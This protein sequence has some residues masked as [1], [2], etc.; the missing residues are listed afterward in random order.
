MLFRSAF[1]GH[2]WDT[3]VFGWR[4][5]GIGYDPSFTQANGGLQSNQPPPAGAVTFQIAPSASACNWYVLQTAHTGTMQVGMGDGSCRGV[6]S[7]ILP[8]T[9]WRACDPKDGLPLG[10][11]W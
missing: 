8:T 2:G 10:N 5:M 7:G 11:D 9:W 4:E 3:P 6:G 1:V